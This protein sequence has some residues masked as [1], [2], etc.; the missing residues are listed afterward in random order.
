MPEPHRNLVTIRETIGAFNRGDLARMEQ[1]VHPDIVY[2]VSGKSPVAG[3]YRGLGAFVGLLDKVRQLSGGSLHL[4]VQD[5]L[6]DDRTVMLMARITARRK[7]K[8]L[9]QEQAYWYRF[10]PDGRLLAGHTIPI[11][12]YAFDAFWA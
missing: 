11:D 12:L 8:T 10:G 3:E 4:E 6:A 5:A 2:R 1:L 7:G 9:D